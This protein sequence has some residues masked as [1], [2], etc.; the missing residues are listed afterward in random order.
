MGL[1]I[2]TNVASINAQ[3]SLAGTKKDLDSSLEKLSSGLRINKA[4]DDAA[5]LAVSENLKAQIRSL[6]QAKRN[7]ND[8][9]SMI[10][11]AEGGLNEVSNI[12]IRLR[13]LSIQASS[14]TIGDTERKF[15]NVEY[16]QLKNEIQ[17]IAQVT[18]FNG[19]SLLT[20]EGP[21]LSIQVG[22]H[23]NAFEDRIIYPTGAQNAK[24]D[25]LGIAG[26]ATDSKTAAQEAIAKIDV[27]IVG[28]NSNRA[29]LGALQNRLSSTVNN[30]SV[31]EENMSASNS[32]IRDVDVAQETA[33][34]VRNN[35]LH[36]AG[37]S[38]LSNANASNQA[39]L[40]LL[41]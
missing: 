3:R 38:V 22:T 10:Q 5:G 37:I 21:E 39:A 11:T 41:G 9:I 28:I 35:I 6:G 15:V 30:L 19:T 16:Q 7:A 12:L 32:R 36:Q 27:A 18:N 13:E 17:R 33:N 26:I 2:N 8:G 1:R 20:G 31:A 25:K 23:N 40:K 24:L 34:M 4:G 29:N 14:D